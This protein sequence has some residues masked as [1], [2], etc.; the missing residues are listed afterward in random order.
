VVKS[1]RCKSACLYSNIIKKE[2]K[3]REKELEKEYK[4][5]LARCRK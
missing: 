2:W 4:Q 3:E 1:G 5:L